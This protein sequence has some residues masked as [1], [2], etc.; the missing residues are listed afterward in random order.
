MPS[1]PC[2]ACVLETNVVCRH[3]VF[4]TIDVYIATVFISSATVST[5]S[6]VAPAV[7]LVSSGTDAGAFTEALPLPGGW[8][9]LELIDP[10]RVVEGKS[11]LGRGVSIDTSFS[12]GFDD[13]LRVSE[14]VRSVRGVGA[15]PSSATRARGL[16]I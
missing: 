8:F 12:G 7:V 13:R 2:G 11:P 14:S 16:E 5:S 6:F 15:G 10:E 4:P 3:D 1:A 9:S